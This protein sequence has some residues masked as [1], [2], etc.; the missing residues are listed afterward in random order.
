[1][2]GQS[3]YSEYLRTVSHIFT[4]VKHFTENSVR[5][6]KIDWKA[7]TGRHIDANGSGFPQQKR[8][9]TARLDPLVKDSPR[10]SIAGCFQAEHMLYPGDWVTGRL[11]SACRRGF[12]NGLQRILR[13]RAF[14]FL[15]EDFLVAGGIDQPHEKR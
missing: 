13:Q 12:I 6:T 8:R 11:F 4:V 5:V 14:A 2:C 3:N 15:D 9:E 7:N 10:E 1:M